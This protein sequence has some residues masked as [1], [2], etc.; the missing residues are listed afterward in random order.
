MN[1]R[2]GPRVFG[3]DGGHPFLG[4]ELHAAPDYSSA[5]AAEIDREI[6]RIVKGAYQLAKDVLRTRREALETISETL[7]ER[8]TIEREELEALLNRMLDGDIVADVHAIRV[9]QSA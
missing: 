1:Q 7:L 8:E 6:S 3:R 2:L 5:T 4:R 9:A